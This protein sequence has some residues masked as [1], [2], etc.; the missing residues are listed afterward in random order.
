ME[1]DGTANISCQSFCELNVALVWLKNYVTMPWKEGNSY[2]YV[3][4][5][6]S[7]IKKTFHSAKT[8]NL[9]V[10]ENYNVKKYLF[11]ITLA[12]CYYKATASYSLQLSH[13]KK[14]FA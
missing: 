3:I 2:F 1:T 10:R 7:K 6:Y 4:L 13:E 8:Q 12:Y 5:I 9:Y 14:V 11:V